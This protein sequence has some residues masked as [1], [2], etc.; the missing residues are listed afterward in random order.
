[1]HSYPLVSRVAAGSKDA[2]A[3]LSED[4]ARILRL[5]EQLTGG[6]AAP[7][8]TPSERQ[9]IAK[10]L[11]IESSKHEAVEELY[12]WPVVRKSVEGGA[13]LAGAAIE[14]ETR[15][16]RILHEL[17]HV[18]AG[19]D[20]FRTLAYHVASV[21]RD[22]ITLEES[23]VWPKLRL[24]L[25]DDELQRLGSQMEAAKPAAPTR[26]HPHT[27]PDPGVLKTVGAAAAMLDRALDALT[28]RGR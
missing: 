11:V 26:P 8:G 6:A 10:R 12:F 28:G 21:V 25:G 7:S 27:P 13:D 16:K 23:Q 14:Q 17:D 9:R 22:H 5:A 18:P 15:A 3:V 24:A 20:D 4:H 1:M 2:F 19:T